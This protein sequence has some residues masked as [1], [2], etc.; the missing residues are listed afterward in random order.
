MVLSE[1][2]TQ[3]TGAIQR[4]SKAI[5]ITDAETIAFIDQV[6]TSLLKAD[7]NVEQ[8]KQIRSGLN[9][10]AESNKSVHTT[11]RHRA[12]EARLVKELYDILNCPRGGV[13][14]LKGIV[15]FVGIQG[16]GK[17]TTIMKYARWYQKTHKIKVGMVCAD[18]YR[19]G[20]FSQ[21]KENARL[22][23]CECYG[24]DNETD[25]VV[26][27][28]IGVE[29]LQKQGCELILV[30]TSGRH[31]QESVLFIE[32][33]TIVARLQPIHTIFVLDGTIGQV[34]REQAKAFRT[35][36]PLGSVVLTKMD[37]NN[38]KGGGVLSAVA[39]AGV[40]VSHLG[41]GEHM[42]DFEVFDPKR[43][44]ARLLGKG[45]L[46]GLFE[47]CI[48]EGVLDQPVAKGLVTRL[49]GQPKVKFSFR[50]L[51]EHL[52]MM[53]SMG[54]MTKFLGMFPGMDAVVAKMTTNN[55]DPSLKLKKYMIIL[56]SMTS[57]ELDHDAKLFYKEP[58]R[59]R[60]VA[61]GAGIAESMVEEL[62]QKFKPFQQTM[63]AMRGHFG[64]VSSSSS[65]ILKKKS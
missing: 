48:R 32:M 63:K 25:P 47:L 31:G 54:S 65:S 57:W 27:A 61:W 37:G 33:Q 64:G 21:L 26:V 5:V 4:L 34:A 22:V 49:F 36:I 56:N 46:T 9:K 1:L 12:L 41:T 3:L 60:R 42:E 8:V 17:T 2:G 24:D 15:L 28:E 14:T 10:E 50:D 7:V 23:G 35:A 53:N 55:N 11:V 43:F 13:T 62:L 18:T 38:A 19:A 30:D 51:S 6:C 39:S 58:K 44:I 59:I 20:A 45:D 16:A 52:K 40:A 29:K